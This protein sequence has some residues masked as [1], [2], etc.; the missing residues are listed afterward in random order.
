MGNCNASFNFN[1]LFDGIKPAFWSIHQLFSSQN[2][3]NYSQWF[4]FVR[5]S[6]QCAIS[7]NNHS[8]LRCNVFRTVAMPKRIN[9]APKFARISYILQQTCQFRGYSGQVILREKVHQF[10]C[11]WIPFAQCLHFANL[12]KSLKSQLNKKQNGNDCI[13]GLKLTFFS[14]LH[15]WWSVSCNGIIPILRNWLKGL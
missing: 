9:D 13:F 14:C 6:F 5:I 2:L 7:L 4:M 11:L 8:Q 1:V 3:G 15:F 12:F 10:L